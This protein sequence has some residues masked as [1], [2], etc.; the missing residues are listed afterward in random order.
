MYTCVHLTTS[1]RGISIC[2]KRAWIPQQRISK[3]KANHKSN[4]R[5]RHNDGQKTTPTQKSRTRGLSTTN[6]MECRE[7]DRQRAQMYM[8]QQ[9]TSV[10]S[11]C[12]ISFPLHCQHTESFDCRMFGICPRLRVGD[13]LADHRTGLI[14]G[15]VVAGIGRP[16]FHVTSN[17]SNRLER[18]QLLGPMR[19]RGRVI[20]T[21]RHRHTCP[22]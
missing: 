21:D 6:S 11:G 14:A 20:R 8:P 12:C 17:T 3:T 19:F 16:G 18:A 1:Q 15:S 5:M 7:R 2:S 13:N 10:L 22:L 9:N 4:R